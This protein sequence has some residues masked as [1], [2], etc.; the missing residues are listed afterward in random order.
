MLHAHN[1]VD[2]YPWGPEALERAKTEGKP[3]FL[4][5]GYTSCYWCHVMERQVFENEEIAAYL[6]EHFVCIKV[7]REERP[8]IDEL[9]MLCLQVY[10]QLAGSNQ[11]GGWP[12][13]IFLTP[14]AK[15]IAGGTYFPPTDMPGRPG[16]MTILKNVTSAWAERQADVISTSE[17]NAK[18]VKRL[19]TPQLVLQPVALN[20]TLVAK[21]IDAISSSYDPEYGGFDFSK[22]A[23]DAPKFPIPARLE[24]LQ[25][26][27]PFAADEKII[28]AATGEEIISVTSK[29]DVLARPTEEDVVP[30]PAIDDVTDVGRAGGVEPPGKEFVAPRLRRVEAANLEVIAPVGREHEVDDRGILALELIVARGDHFSAGIGDGQVGVEALPLVAIE[31]LRHHLEIQQ[32]TTAAVD[33]V[34]VLLARRRHRPDDVDRGNDQFVAGIE[35][36]TER[37]GDRQ[38]GK[39]QALGGAEAAM[40]S[41][42]LGNE[43]PTV[44]HDRGPLIE[45]ELDR[46]TDTKKMARG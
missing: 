29:E 14:E 37:V 19:S 8:D 16:F 26:I 39:G 12:L 5:V 34:N 45:G 2:W 1:P 46:L 31:S 42:L 21:S 28:A 17:L 18:E 27:G 44:G 10:L 11:G 4:S 24:L 33:P 40:R 38:G 35:P 43:E 36:A 6:N 15:P 13:S 41:R 20:S 32:V 22:D 7:D 3:I 30:V 25:T 23:A 9:Y